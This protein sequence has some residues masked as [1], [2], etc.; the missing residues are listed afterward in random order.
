M[1]VGHLLFLPACYMLCLP[2]AGLSCVQ[3]RGRLTC[4]SVWENKDWR[5]DFRSKSCTMLWC[6]VTTVQC[7]IWDHGGL[8]ERGHSDV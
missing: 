2:S 8:R 4:R 1:S 5:Q 3:N 6:F 7:L